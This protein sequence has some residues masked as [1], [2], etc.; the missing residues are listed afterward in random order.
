MNSL[1]NLVTSGKVLYLGISDTPAWIVADANRYARE[2]AKTPFVIYQGRWNVL[3]RDFER[4]IIPM[5]RHL[6][7]ALAPWDVLA[8]GKIRTDAEEEA[9]RKT[10][11][12]GRQL[13]SPSWERNEDE[14]KI[15]AALEK[16]ASEVGAKSVQA[17][18]SLLL[19]LASPQTLTCL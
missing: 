8:G 1:H 4:E 19:H 5:A 18:P 6:G 12:K 14:K 15:V 16:V 11:E 2:H 17:G 13:F 10:G 9:R 7:L 3:S